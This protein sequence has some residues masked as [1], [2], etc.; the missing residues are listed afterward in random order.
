MKHAIIA[1]IAGQYKSLM[2]L[3]EKIPKDYT[4]HLLG[5]LVDRG[6]DSDLVLDW[7]I[8]NNISCVLAN[9]EHMMVDFYRKKREY[10][11]GIWLQNGGTSTHL[12]YV[13]GGRSEDKLEKHLQWI[14]SLPRYKILDSNIEKFK[15]VMISHAP[16]HKMWDKVEDCTDDLDDSILWNRSTP[17]PREHFQVNGHNSHWGLKEYILGTEVFGICLD[18]SRKNKLTCLLL[19]DLEIIQE[20]Y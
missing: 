7:A 13:E 1:D 2:R 4:I 17:I 10:S 20:D 12:H 9:H 18:D 5:D 3:V 15:T 14:E 11:H 8:E 19:P 6:P 16:L